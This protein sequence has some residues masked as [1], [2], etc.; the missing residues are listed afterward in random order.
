MP[1]KRKSQNG[2]ITT[3]TTKHQR[4][5]KKEPGAEMS[6][7]IRNVPPG[8]NWGWFS[9]EDTRMHLQPVDKEHVESGYKI[10]LEE[11]GKRAIVPVGD[12]PAKV[13]KR[14]LADLEKSRPRVESW[15]AAFMIDQGWLQQSLHGSIITLTAYPNHPGSRF[16]RYLDLADY[17]AG[18]YSPESQM[19]PA[20]KR[21]VKP[22]EVVLRSELCAIEIFPQKEEGRRHHIYLPPILWQD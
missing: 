19:S 22:E 6:V 3:R 15:W 4:T 7:I 14:L 17:L 10:W 11:K 5:T 18:Y 13:L 21:P 8:Y 9:R 12:I 1:V 2:A 16:T 20:E